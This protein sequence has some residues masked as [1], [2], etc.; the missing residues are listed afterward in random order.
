MGFFPLTNVFLTLN[1]SLRKSWIVRNDSFRY[2]SA[3][4]VL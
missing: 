4:R 1:E 2:D 3:G